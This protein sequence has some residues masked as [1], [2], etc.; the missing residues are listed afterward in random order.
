M[1]SLLHPARTSAQHT[2]KSCFSG[3][4]H[5]QVPPRPPR[6]VAV[7]AAPVWSAQPGQ[8]R[9]DSGV[10]GHRA[11]SSGG[12]RSSLLGVNAEGTPGQ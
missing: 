3:F 12:R 8:L 6:F 1:T 9:F 2:A 7:V 4:K 11:I 5:V 10:A